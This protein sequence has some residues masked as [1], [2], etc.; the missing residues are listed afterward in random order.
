MLKGLKLRKG[1]RFTQ[2]DYLDAKSTILSRLEKRGYAYA[3]V[4]GRAFIFPG[5]RKARIRFVADPGP[6]ARFGE[7]RI[8]G[9]DSVPEKYVREVLA[10]EPGDPYSSR[11]LQ[12]TQQQIYA[13]EVFSLVSVL[14]AHQVAEEQPLSEEEDNKE[15]SDEAPPTRSRQL[16]EEIRT[17]GEPADEAAP[18]APSRRLGISNLLDRAQNEAEARTRLSPEV[19]IVVRLKEARAWNVRVGA[20][21]AV[22]SNRQDVHGQVDVSSKNVFGGLQKLNWSNTAGHAWAPGF[23]YPNRAGARNRGII[24]ESTLAFTQPFLRDP[25]TNIR[26]IPSV[27][28]DIQV[29]YTLWNPGARLGIDTTFFDHLTLRGGY[30][31]SYFNFNNISPNL[32]GETP[33]GEDF[34]PEFM[35]EFLE[36]G[37]ALDYRDNPLNPTSGFLT[38]FTIQEAGSYIFGGEFEYL[39]AAVS[40]QGYVPFFLLTEWVMAARV[41]VGSIYNIEPVEREGRDVDTQRVPTISRFFSGGRNSMRSFGR[42]NLSIYKGTVPVG[43]LTLLEASLEPRFRLVPNLAGVGDLWGAVFVDAASVRRGQF[44]FQTSANRSLQLGT[45]SPSDLFSSLLYGVGAGLWWVTPVGPVRFDFAYTVSP[46]DDPRFRQCAD[47]NLNETGD[48]DCEKVPL[49]KDQLQD[50]ILGYNFIFGIGHSF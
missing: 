45:E 14:P 1:R 16:D 30:R 12:R 36:Q 13:L 11:V 21:F 5:E 34:Q 15:E 48:P 40:A 3:E 2:E 24:L 23:L 35:L 8:E 33:L 50:N 42:R 7:V 39:K 46:L 31:L 18:E 20:G 22:E 10:F 17:N 37:I 49:G 43:G 26:V 29:G 9:L 32:S 38:D 4:D 19:P 47:P 41:K 28:R 44:L 25:P 6:K 27:E